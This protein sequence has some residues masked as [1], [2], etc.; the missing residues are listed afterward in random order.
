[1][2]ATRAQTEAP[3]AAPTLDVE[4]TALDLAPPAVLIPPAPTAKP[5]A[6]PVPHPI[7]AIAIPDD[8]PRPCKCIPHHSL[9]LDLVD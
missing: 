8:E 4:H 6:K 9:P 5:V 7:A 2:L 3:R 1:M